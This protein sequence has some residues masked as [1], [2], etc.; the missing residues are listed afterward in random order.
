MGTAWSKE[1]TKKHHF[2]SSFS[3]TQG[4]GFSLMHKLS[5]RQVR[6]CSSRV[7]HLPSG[8]MQYSYKNFMQTLLRLCRFQICFHD[9]RGSQ[10]SRIMWET[11]FQHTHVCL[12]VSVTFAPAKWVYN[13]CIHSQECDM[14][15]VTCLDWPI[16]PQ[17][18]RLNMG[19]LLESIL[20]DWNCA[21][22]LTR[23]PGMGSTFLKG[24]RWSGRRGRVRQLRKRIEKTERG[25]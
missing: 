24:G 2:T 3:F 16:I 10:P 15:C 25:C 17:N 14:S 5:I 7:W 13:I 18:P 20:F 1:P 9:F 22:F 12:A 6:V 19:I 8:I 4:F 23:W 11:T 21:S